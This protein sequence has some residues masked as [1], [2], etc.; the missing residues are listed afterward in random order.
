[1]ARVLRPGGAL[2]ISTTI[3]RARPSIAFNAH[4]IYDSRM[5][6]TMRGGLRLER[7]LFFTHA[8]GGAAPLDQIT[9]KPGHWDVYCGCWIK[10]ETTAA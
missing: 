6:A 5:L 1:M 9:D 7:E 10:P 4:R 8:R 2:V 3:T